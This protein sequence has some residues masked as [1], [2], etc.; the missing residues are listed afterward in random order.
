MFSSG[1]GS[2]NQPQGTLR[3]VL[4]ETPKEEDLLVMAEISKGSR[5]VIVE[6]PFVISGTFRFCLQ[7]VVGRRIGEEEPTW[8]LY[9]GESR[10]KLEWILQTADVLQVQSSI[11]STVSGFSHSSLISPTPSPNPA[12]QPDLAPNPPGVAPGTNP[13]GQTAVQG[14]WQPT[15][16]LPAYPERPTERPKVMDPV[17]AIAKPSAAS[18]MEGDLAK[19]SIESVLDSITKG[20]MTG[21]LECN[22]RGDK[23]EV[24]FENGNARHASSPTA[25]GEDA[26]VEL[27]TAME[28]IFQ[29]VPSVS[30]E[31]RNIFKRTEELS[32]KA[33]SIIDL[34]TFLERA[35]I[36]L[37]SKLTRNNANLTEQEFE[38]AVSP[39]VPVSLDA[40]K[41]FYQLIDNQS[42]LSHIIQT[43]KFGRC[44]WIPTLYNLMSGSLVSAEEELVDQESPA[45]QNLGIDRSTAEQFAR[46]HIYSETGI[47]TFPA[48]LY[49]VEQEFYRYECFQS[50]FSLVMVKPRISRNGEDLPISPEQKQA[51]LAALSGTKRKADLLAHFQQDDFALLLPQTGTDGV[52]AFAGRLVEAL[53]PGPTPRGLTVQPGDLFALTI[54]IASLPDDSQDWVKLVAFLNQNFRRF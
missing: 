35:G 12:G 6:Q 53:N 2:Q 27:M 48:L 39:L 31:P 24:V 7:T 21:R 19:L 40:Q 15:V 14:S 30:T 41:R 33:K 13:I 3:P 44:D 52:R 11:T 18:P 43:G 16:Q 54:G 46:S 51:V 4:H 50:P 28:G 26:L 22:V 23:I 37:N 47:V 8:Y 1:P 34:G 45:N 25:T 49:F 9:S 36:K 17:A 29:F 10:N 20:R 38:N 42:P 32:G 5:G